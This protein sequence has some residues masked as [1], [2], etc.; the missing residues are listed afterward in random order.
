MYLEPPF[1][2]ENRLHRKLTARSSG[3]S[4]HAQ[5]LAHRLIS[6]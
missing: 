4:S 6:Y 2:L 5:F 3:E 1:P